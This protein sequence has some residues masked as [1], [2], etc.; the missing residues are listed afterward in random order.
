MRVLVVVP[1]SLPLPSFQTYQDGYLSFTAREFNSTPAI[2][3]NSVTKPRMIPAAP[4]GLA[5]II[6]SCTMIM[7]VYNQAAAAT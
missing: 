1:T 7:A 5:N 6:R 2:L 4:H 3:V